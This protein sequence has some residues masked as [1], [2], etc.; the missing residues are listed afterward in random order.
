[1]TGGGRVPGSGSLPHPPTHTTG[2]LL[3]APGIKS[4]SVRLWQT[5]QDSLQPSWLG[6]QKGG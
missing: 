3:P 4:K 1:M 2:S 6:D 5:A